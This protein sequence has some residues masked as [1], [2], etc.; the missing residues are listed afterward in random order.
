VVKVGGTSPFCYFHFEHGFLPRFGNATSIAD[1]HFERVSPERC[2]CG[3]QQIKSDA[4]L[5]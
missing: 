2:G 3:Y 5:E 1:A 4:L